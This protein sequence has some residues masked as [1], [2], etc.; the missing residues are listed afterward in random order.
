VLAHK[1]LLMATLPHPSSETDKKFVNSAR[2][3]R[4]AVTKKM[5]PAQIANAQKSAREWKPTPQT[6]AI[7]SKG[8]GSPNSLSRRGR[9]LILFQAVRWR[10][11]IECTER[12]GAFAKAGYCVSAQA[13]SA[14]TRP[15]PQ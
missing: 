5:T 7:A 2:Y 12:A 15:A 6:E 13:S 8:T 9:L 4:A 3:K 11:L 1:R 14:N 10:A